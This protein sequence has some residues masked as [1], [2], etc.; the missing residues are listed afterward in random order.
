[1]MTLDQDRKV[2]EEHCT[3]RT[4]QGSLVQIDA[5]GYQ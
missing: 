1:M 3:Y 4:S 2:V 5:W